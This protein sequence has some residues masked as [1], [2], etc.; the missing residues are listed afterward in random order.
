MDDEAFSPFHE[1]RAIRSYARKKE[2]TE[3]ELL[4]RGVILPPSSK[5]DIG[6]SSETRWPA[7]P[8][9]LAPY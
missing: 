8:A 3:V 7:I 1:G 9:A 5:L 2:D 6:S 4:G